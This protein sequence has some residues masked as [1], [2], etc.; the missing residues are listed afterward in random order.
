[1]SAYSAISRSENDLKGKKISVTLISGGSSNIRWLE[2]LLWEACS[3][4][5]GSAKPI[6][7]SGSFQEVVA[8]GLAI[9]CARRHYDPD[10]EFV[11]VTYNPLRLL[12]NPDDKGIEQKKY[13]SVENKIDMTGADS[14]ILMPSAQALRNFINEPL[15]WRV[16]L[17]RPP[18]RYM[19]YFFM[20]PSD[21][22]L[23]EQPEDFDNLYNVDNVLHTSSD[24]KFEGRIRIQLIVREDGTT[25]PKFIYKMGNE[26]IGVNGHWEDGKPFVIDMTSE[27]Q[28][29]DSSRYIGFDFG[30]SNTSLCFIT[31]RDIHEINLRSTDSSWLEL[32]ELIPKLPY[33]ISWPIRKY[34]S[35]KNLDN[36]VE[37]ARDAYE[38]ML[39]FAAYTAACELI[40]TGGMK[41]TIMK[42]FQHRSMGP[43]K[44]LLFN[45]LQRLGK[46]PEFAKPFWTIFN[47]FTDETNNAIKEF[48]EH[49]HKKR[50]SMEVN[51]HEHLRI[52]ANICREFMTN[53][54]FGYFEYTQAGRFRK[55]EYSGTFRI[56]HDNRPFYDSCQ[57]S[58][59]ECFELSEPFIVDL[60]NNRALSLLPFYFFEESASNQ[61]EN[62]C[63]VFDKIV[64]EKVS[65]KVV[66]DD[67]T[68][69]LT[70][71]Y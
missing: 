38:S 42:S 20:R 4:S 10:S 69:E 56:A 64:K 9:E 71:E 17:N 53:K 36:S 32:K 30:T 11:S 68:N 19:K 5:L 65:F 52:L 15:Q 50:S 29:I 31:N 6:P 55:K 41:P 46:N 33:P 37:N 48:N 27:N 54:V 16:K 26:D 35:I 39:C 34:L 18:R 67:Q 24:T 8:K 63:Y 7:L 58:C 44:D 61:S 14:C 43:L 2:K 28:V 23:H 57:Y 40:A 47:R 25:I 13:T 51:A 22:P 3:D 62:K 70:E 60:I 49:K 12:L 59:N 1:M 21:K 66:D 45:C